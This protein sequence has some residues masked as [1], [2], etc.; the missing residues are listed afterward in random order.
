MSGHLKEIMRCCG[1]V[2]AFRVVVQPFFAGLGF[3]GI[4]GLAKPG[5]GFRVDFSKARPA[6]Q[7][8]FC[9]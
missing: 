2:T 9:H 7:C 3:G 5:L 1:V 4:S 6:T 8:L